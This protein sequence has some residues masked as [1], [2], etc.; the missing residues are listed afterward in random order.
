[1]ISAAEYSSPS[2]YLAGL[3]SGITGSRRFNVVEH[4]ANA[5]WD[6]AIEE[7]QKADETHLVRYLCFVKALYEGGT[8]QQA[9]DVVGLT[10]DTQLVWSVDF[11]TNQ[12]FSPL[13][14]DKQH[15]HL[16][17]LRS[18]LGGEMISLRRMAKT[19]QSTKGVA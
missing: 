13:I 10:F 8:Q 11:L 3:F 12:F 16:P 15:L 17:V 5:E 9:G 18:I 14:G 1:V 4:L 7:A 2:E 19:S 6:G